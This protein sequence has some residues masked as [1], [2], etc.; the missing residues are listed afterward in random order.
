M[1]LK[2]KLLVKKYSVEIVDAVITDFQSRYIDS[3]QHEYFNITPLGVIELKKILAWLLI[4]IV[5]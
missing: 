5:S 1:E 2:K 3:I 4:F